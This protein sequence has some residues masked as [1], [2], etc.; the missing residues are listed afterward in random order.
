[1]L[2][3]Y[4]CIAAINGGEFADAGGQG[5]GA[6]P[7]GLT[8]SGGKNVWNDGLKRSFFGFDKND[9]LVC[10]EGMTKAEADKLG[11]RDAVSF[12][13]G[14]CSFSKTERISSFSMPTA[15]PAQRAHRNRSACRRHGHIAC[16]R[17]Q[18]G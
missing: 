2:Q 8:F 7:M 4:N 5:T 15:T 1:M 6:K 9:R 12:Q 16:D 14:M 11:I 18:I 13:T 17:R 10:R 3:K